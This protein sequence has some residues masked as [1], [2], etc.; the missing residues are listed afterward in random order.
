MR[1]KPLPIKEMT[2]AFFVA[3]LFILAAYYSSEYE[4][5]LQDTFLD[6]SEWAMLLYTAAAA[7]AIVVAPIST[8][9]LLPVAVAL[10][11]SFTAALLSIFGWT[12]GGIL[13]FLLSREIGRPLIRRFVNMEKAQKVAYAISGGN[14]FWSIVFLRIILPVDILSYAIGLFVRVPLRTY[15][16]ATLVGVAPFAFIFSYTV[17]L[18]SHLQVIALSL[19]AVA[20]IFGYIYIGKRIQNR[21]SEI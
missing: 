15:A 8:F 9:P 6:E 11:G 10:W 18:S 3:L 17:P 19:A 13:A 20:V 12:I 16:L 21:K 14:L 1:G 2:G 5:Y 4:S 7:L